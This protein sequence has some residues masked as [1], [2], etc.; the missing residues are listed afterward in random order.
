MSLLAF[1][2][3]EGYADDIGRGIA[4]IDEDI[5]RMLDVTSGDTVEIQAKR[6]TYAKCLPLAPSDEGKEI[7]RIDGLIRNNSGCN[8][9]DTITIKKSDVYSAS[10]VILKPLDEQDEKLEKINQF[11]DQYLLGC[12]D[13][14]PS[15]QGDNIAV[16]YDDKR[17]FF[18][19]IETNPM[20]APIEICKDTVFHIVDYV[21]LRNNTANNRFL[22]TIK[23]R[24]AKGEITR[25]EFKQMKEDLKD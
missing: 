18:Q 6:K 2:V 25:E 24:Y 19:V 9:D 4:R 1:K 8:I 21:D 14:I 20:N 5:M 17:L 11:D 3:S 7:I 23:D 13:G 22:D 16:P 12:L 10:K 15:I